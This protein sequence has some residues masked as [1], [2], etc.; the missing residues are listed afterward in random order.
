MSSLV[1]DFIINPV[2]RQARRFSEISRTNPTEQNAQQTGP[3]EAVS[4]VAEDEDAGEAET[5][6]ED[7]V[8]PAQEATP[9]TPA[10]LPAATQVTTPDQE[11]PSRRESA[12]LNRDHLGF[13]L[14]PKRP[15]G[16]IPEDDGMSALR[17]RIHSINAQ[18]IPQPDK[19][20]LIHEILLEGYRSSRTSPLGHASL[21]RDVAN[22]HTHEYSTSPPLSL[23]SLKFWQNQVGESAAAEK[24]LLTDSDLAPTYAPIR[25]PKNADGS[26]DPPTPPTTDRPL[27]CQHYERNVKLQCSTCDKWYT[28]RFCHDAVESHNL[29]RHETKHM[30]CMLCGTPQR[31][32][33]VCINCGET[34]AQYYCN[35]CKLWENRKSKPIYHC[36]DC[37]ICRRG[38][39]LGKDFFHCK[40]TSCPTAKDRMRANLFLDV[41][42]VYNNFY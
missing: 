3:P 18:D 19:A 2:L 23:E 14:T 42:C 8:P 5:V 33:E 9:A 25:Q 32:A 28:C 1:S 38:L 40:V 17:A 4:A 26:K 15:G 29:I 10:P 30:L 7:L 37:G 41:P 20:R 39:G 21:E 24:F 27:G 6:Q 31:A 13:P 22:S 36:N 35:I 34:T 12:A 11:S 16:P